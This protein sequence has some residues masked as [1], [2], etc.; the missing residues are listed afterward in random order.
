MQC[1]YLMESTH[2]RRKHI[3]EPNPPPYFLQQQ[4]QIVT[5]SYNFRIP[6]SGAK[7]VWEHTNTKIS[8]LAFLSA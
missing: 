1:T 4:V 2:P 6:N 8:G 3:A 5:S 7:N